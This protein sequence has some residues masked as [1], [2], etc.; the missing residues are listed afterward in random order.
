[1]VIYSD[2]RWFIGKSPNW[3]VYFPLP[4][5]ITG[6][7]P[8]STYRGDVTVGHRRVEQIHATHLTVYPCCRDWLAYRSIETLRYGK[9]GVCSTETCNM[10]I[11]LKIEP[12]GTQISGTTWYNVQC[13]IVELPLKITFE[14]KWTTTSEVNFGSSHWHGPGGTR[15]WTGLHLS[16]HGMV[17]GCAHFPKLLERS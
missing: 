16:S 7:Y 9:P 5:L 13:Y 15:I 12:R 4:C 14:D 2:L 3:I 1:M 10:K 6:G 8:L 11:T 17:I